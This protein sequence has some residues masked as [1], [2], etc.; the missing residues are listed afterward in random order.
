MAIIKTYYFFPLCRYGGHLPVGPWSLR[1]AKQRSMCTLR[2]DTFD[3]SSASR[4]LIPTNL[5]LYDSVTS[6]KD[7]DMLSQY[8]IAKNLKELSVYL[9]SMHPVNLSAVVDASGECLLDIPT[10]AQPSTSGTSDQSAVKKKTILR[11]GTGKKVKFSIQTPSPIP[12]ENGN[13]QCPVCSKTFK[14]SSNCRKHSGIHSKEKMACTICGYKC[15]DPSNFKR[16]CERHEREKTYKCEHCNKVFYTAVDIKAHEKTHEN[17]KKTSGPC[18]LKGCSKLGHPF[19]DLCKHI[20]LTHKLNNLQAYFDR[21]RLERALTTA[22]ST[23]RCQCREHALWIWKWVGDTHNCS[24]CE[25]FYVFR[26]IHATDKSNARWIRACKYI[27]HT[28]AVA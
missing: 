13:F 18:I 25:C 17:I 15:S 23:E 28:K 22:P 21:I 4:Y 5:R 3:A 24:L 16:H 7:Y 9:G 19:K 26:R 8:K 14:S 11:K 20:R 6:V 12:C 27:D 10:P 2:F 1:E